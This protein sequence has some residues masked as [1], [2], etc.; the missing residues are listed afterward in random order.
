MEI[1]QP[2]GT[3]GILPKTGQVTSFKDYD[4]GYYQE[5]WPQ[6]GGLVATRFVDNGNGTISDRATRLMWVKQPEL[7]IPG[8]SVIASNQIQRA[9]SD[10]AISTDYLIGDLV[11][12]IVVETGTFTAS[13][14]ATTG[15]VTASAAVFS[16]ADIGR[17][18]F[19][20][21]VSQ[22]T[23][24]TYTDSTHVVVTT[25]GTTASNPL[26]V[27]S[28]FI[29]IVAGTSGGAGTVFTTDP[30]YPTK[31]RETNWTSSAA[32]LTTPRTMVWDNT[33]NSVNALEMSKNLNYAGYTD[34]KLPNVK[35]LMSIVDYGLVSPSI[36]ATAFPNTQSNYYW[37]STIYADGTGYAWVVDFG[38]GSVNNDFRGYGYYVRPV[39]Q[40]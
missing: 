3:P 29:C 5:G 8:A 12:A 9:K 33:Y 39:R 7:I 21:G 1:I 22:G 36:N 32:N 13:R 16:A 38:S 26:V 37:S 17:E 19:I 25:A 2:F 6:E 31:W 10:W 28:Y 15:I 18:I 30:M 20:N 27:K 24:K 34:W 23:V 35:E 4:D 14:A 40:Y 11:K